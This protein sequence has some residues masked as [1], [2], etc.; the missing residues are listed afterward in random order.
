MLAI[1]VDRLAIAMSG[2]H[3]VGL[4]RLTNDLANLQR[5]EYDEDQG[6]SQP[7]HV[8]AIALLEFVVVIHR[9]D[10]HDSS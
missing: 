3:A 5:A 6:R 8:L 7:K 4:S 1:R 2:R 10:A 9:A